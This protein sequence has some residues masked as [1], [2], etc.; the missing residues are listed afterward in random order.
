MRVGSDLVLKNCRPRGEGESS[1]DAAKGDLSPALAKPL[2]PPACACLRGS[3]RLEHLHGLARFA[4]D[5][6][7]RLG[8][9][10]GK[11]EGHD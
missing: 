8:D 7:I 2:E 4:Y 5:N 10:G 3:A 1:G 9:W 6:Q 11:G